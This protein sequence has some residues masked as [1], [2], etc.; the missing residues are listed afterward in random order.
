MKRHRAVAAT[1]ATCAGLITAVGATPAAANHSWDGYHWARQSNPFTVRLGDNLSTSAW[2]A[3][4]GAASADWSNS[5]VL[6]APVVPGR[7]TGKRCRPTSG[8]V[9]V[10]NASYGRNG[11]LGLASIWASGSHI[12]QGTVKLN[13]TYFNTATY[14]TPAWRRSVTCQEVGHTFGLDHQSEDPNVNVSTC[15]DYYKIPN[16]SPNQHD[17]DQL[18]LIY[19]HLDSTTT[20]AASAEGSGRRLKRVKDSLFVEDLGKGH[21]R[22]VWV[23]WKDQGVAHGAPDED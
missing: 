19:S 8:R 16:P 18:A 1:V 22:F 2:D 14:N 12:T 10:C 11:W 15:M 23:L 21:K 17:Y 3:A 6:D 20:L 13:D 5:N 7:T 9:E 4:L